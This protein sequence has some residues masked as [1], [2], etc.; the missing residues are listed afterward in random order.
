M[1]TWRGKIPSCRFAGWCA[2]SFRRTLCSARSAAHS[3]RL[4]DQFNTS[5]LG[6]FAFLAILLASIGLYGLIPYSVEQRTL[7]FGIRLA[8]DA[9]FARVRNM[10]MRQAMTLALAGIVI[11]LEAHRGSHA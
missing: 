7:E 9:D 8:L 1:L 2:A 4:P 11:G 10:V 3:N 5:V 6:I